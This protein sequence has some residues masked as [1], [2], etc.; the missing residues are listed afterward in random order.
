MKSSPRLPQL[1]KSPNTTTKTHHSQK[2][3][4]YINLFF[5]QIINCK[6]P[7]IVILV[8]IFDTKIQ[9]VKIAFNFPFVTK[10]ISYQS[11]PPSN[12]SE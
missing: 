10:D 8:D 9:T 11:V 5:F 1:E 3:N 2:E 6:Y 7:R 4:K 12:C